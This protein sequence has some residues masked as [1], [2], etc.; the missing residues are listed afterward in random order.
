MRETL[1]GRTAAL[2]N[3][4]FVPSNEWHQYQ[5]RTDPTTHNFI[6][7][8]KTA[9]SLFTIL[10]SDQAVFR[11]ESKSTINVYDTQCVLRMAHLTKRV[12]WYRQVGLF[13]AKSNMIV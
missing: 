4:S 6:L 5:Q 13:C 12:F 1:E 3:A 8:S 2:S 9:Y 7:S 10:S 11:T